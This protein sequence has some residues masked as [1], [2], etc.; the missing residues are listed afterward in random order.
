MV[1]TGAK[2][3]VDRRPR[4]P[5]I[6]AQLGFRQDFPRN[7][8]EHPAVDAAEVIVEA[9]GNEQLAI[10]DEQAAV[11][12]KRG[13]EMAMNHGFSL[14]RSGEEAPDELAIRKTQRVAPDRKSP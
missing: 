8:I 12:R 2:D 1:G 13:T 11:H 5:G 3:V 7:R 10:E 9:S 4:R 14:E 6:A